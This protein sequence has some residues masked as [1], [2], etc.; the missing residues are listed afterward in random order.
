V[1]QVAGLET[2]G[3]KQRLYFSEIE[4]TKYWR[5]VSSQVSA[6]K[7]LPL[8]T[9]NAVG[10]REHAR[11]SNYLIFRT[12]VTLTLTMEAAWSVI[13]YYHYNQTA[14]HQNLKDHT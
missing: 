14:W 7:K 1:L 6:P 8:P 10:W 12:D 4:R 2:R 11:G 5:C 3:G 13:R 9:F